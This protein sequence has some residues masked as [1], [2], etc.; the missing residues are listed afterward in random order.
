MGVDQLNVELEA[1]PDVRR[2]SRT[3]GPP[4]A[5]SAA[6]G[7]TSMQISL[8]ALTSRSAIDSGFS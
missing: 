2:R 3:T 5:S 7:S 6:S 1:A 4:S 8:P